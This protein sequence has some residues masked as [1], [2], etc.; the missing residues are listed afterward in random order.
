MDPGIYREPVP[1]FIDKADPTNPSNTPTD[2]DVYVRASELPRIRAKTGTE[3]GNVEGAAYGNVQFRNL[4][5]GA[6]SLS[7]NASYGTRT[8]NAYLATFETPILSNPD[9]TLSVGGLKSAHLKP[10]AS[11]EEVLRGTTAQLRWATPY[12]HNGIHSRDPRI[13]ST[14]NLSY[15]GAWRQ[16][17]GLAMTASPTVRFE[18]GDSTKSSLTHMWISD[19]R[20]H[21]YLPANGRLLKTVN[22]IAGVG[23]LGG[24][25][26]FLKSEFE[27]SA[28]IPI[29]NPLAAKNSTGISGFSLTTGFRTGVLY[30]LPVGFGGQANPSRIND[31]FQLG[32]PTDVRG[33]RQ[34][35][36]GPRDGADSLGGD[37]YAAGSI[38]LLTPFPRVS[39]ETPLRLQMFL[40]GGRLVSLSGK[41]GKWDG[42][43]VLG[44]VQGGVREVFLGGAPSLAAGVGIVY[45]HPAARFELNFSLP[46]VVRRGEEARKGLQFGV[47]LSFL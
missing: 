14:H 31:R 4:F 45:A 33:F 27:A 19:T 9:L 37:V 5:G 43:N 17:T 41:N 3:I 30:P 2:V 29:P 7:L 6:E 46:L 18:A 8:R 28:G 42:S 20:D 11:H 34:G 38:N 40:N 21:P 32:G 15:T 35:G 10:W 1:V 47:G 24:D 12:V 39:P 23:P 26:G 16:I 44:A 25:V 13:S 36:I 22:E